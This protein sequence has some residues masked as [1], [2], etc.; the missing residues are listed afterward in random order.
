MVDGGTQTSPLKVLM[1][2]KMVV[3]SGK[4]KNDD[5]NS[6]IKGG[7]MKEQIL[8]V[9]LFIL[10]LLMFATCN[11]VATVKPSLEGLVSGSTWVVS[12]KVVEIQNPGGQIRKVTLEPSKT[13]KGEFTN[14][15]SLGAY[16][17]HPQK[18]TFTYKKI[19]KGN[20]NFASIKESGENYIFMLRVSV[21]NP[22]QVE[23][24]HIQM[25]DAW[26]GAIKSSKDTLRQIEEFL[27]SSAGK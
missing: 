17:H 16:R 3:T 7:N 2:Q 14:Y 12:G 11:S 23:K 10:L 19:G 20:I 15:A 6:V 5:L 1:H 27:K 25:T 9:G 21:D 24:L 26:F 4:E 22:E 8:V 18:I 13:I